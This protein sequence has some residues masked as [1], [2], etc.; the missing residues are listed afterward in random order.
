MENIKRIF[1]EHSLK[2]VS[3]CRFSQLSGRLITCRAM[4]RI[5][6]NAQTVLVCLFPYLLKEYGERNISRYACVKDYHIIAE[7]TLGG[8]CRQ[9]R[10]EYPENTFVPFADDSPI[11]EVYAAALSGLGVIGDNGLL[12]NET[13]GSWVFIG[14]IV[15]DLVIGIETHEIKSCLKCGRCRRFCTGQA[16]EDGFCRERCVSYITQK[17]GELTQEETRRLIEGGLVWGCD[18]CQEICPMNKNALTEPFEGFLGQ[19]DSLFE[20]DREIRERAYEWRG[21][22]VIERNYGIINGGDERP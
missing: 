17:K 12:I 16:L 4:G 6:Q 22:S 11:P 14:E 3:T 20:P 8:I 9:L 2:E 21:K 18:R 7:K 1:K 19:T 10:E 15:T 5:P 13:Y